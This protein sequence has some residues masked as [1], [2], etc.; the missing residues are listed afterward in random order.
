MNAA[1]KV[2]FSWA[3]VPLYQSFLLRKAL[4]H[5][6]P[7]RVNLKHIHRT[8]ISHHLHCLMYYSLVEP[9][10]DVYALQ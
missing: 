8:Q 7:W 3:G 4:Y 5:H 2:V 1:I 9:S 10:L 6:V